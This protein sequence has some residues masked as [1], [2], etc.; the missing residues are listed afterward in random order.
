M[1]AYVGGRKG[2]FA[3][4]YWLIGDWLR[5]KRCS[6]MFGDELAMETAVLDED[7]VG[8]L[9]GDNHACKINSRDVGFEGVAVAD[10]ATRVGSVQV[11]S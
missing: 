3:A 8:A 7:F 2:I 9:A 11:N 6:Q 10:G 1:P 4:G 5:G